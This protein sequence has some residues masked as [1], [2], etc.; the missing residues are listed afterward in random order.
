MRIIEG[1][2]QRD[3]NLVV[4]PDGDLVEIWRAQSY[5]SLRD[6]HVKIIDAA[7]GNTYDLCEI[8]RCRSRM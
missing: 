4:T 5:E 2:R 7:S 6:N 1:G 3:G 8:A